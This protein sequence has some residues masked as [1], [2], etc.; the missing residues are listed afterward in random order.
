MSLQARHTPTA[1]I[2]LAGGWSLDRLTP[3]SRL[4]GANGLRTGPDGRIYIAQVSGST[5]SALDVETG[6]LE[7]V[8]AKGSAIVGPDDIAFDAD[9]NL[10]ATEYYQGRV[11]VLDTRGNT[12]VLRDDLPGANGITFHQ[13]RLF[14]N[15]CRIGGRLLELNTAGE[16]VGVLLD[17]LMMPNAMEVG[18]DGLLYYPL[19]G[20]NEIWRIHP[21]GGEPERVAAD[22]GGPDAVKFDP[23]GNVVSTQCGTGDVLRID[24][25]TGEKTVLATVGPGLDNLT[26]VGDRLF[27]S[28]FT[29]AIVEILPDGTTRDALP[30]GLNGPLDVAASSDGRLYVADGAFFYGLTPGR[31]PEVVAMLF[32]PGYPGYVRGVTSPAAGEFRVTTSTGQVSRYRPADQFSEVLAEG[33]DQLYGIDVAPDGSVAVADLGAGRVLAVRTTG[34]EELASGLDRPLGVAFG[35]DGTL[36]VSESGAGRIV[37]VGPAGVDTV[38]DG[39]EQPHG[40]LV[41][42]G[43]LLVVDAGAKEL[44]GVDLGSKA[45][46]TIVANLP[47]GVPPGVTPKPLVGIAPFS[48]PEGPFAGIT[49]G[50]DGALYL[51][52]D[53]DGSVLVLRPGS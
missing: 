50:P 39:F 9:G 28:R 5:I 34:V 38:A 36:Y 53:A 7:T 29:G 16:I 32:T 8:S 51:S 22:L 47:V 25:R 26:F 49:A 4:F 23:Q 41:R 45:R 44:V 52:A 11:T 1:P 37:T 24:P 27:V 42:D 10:Y 40:V 19:L 20:T 15:E 12:R 46:Q 6:E 17:G 48:G 18:P 3:P 13:G 14:V 35:P 33:F 43:Q 2:G 31:A 30:A 21:D